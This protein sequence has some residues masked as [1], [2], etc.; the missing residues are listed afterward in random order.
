MGLCLC[1]GARGR[2]PQK[3]RD[4]GREGRSVPPSQR[5]QPEGRQRGVVAPKRRGVMG[6]GDGVS[7][8]AGGRTGLL[9]GMVA[10]KRRGIT[11][12]RDGMACPATG[13]TFWG[14]AGGR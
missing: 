2:S 13:R 9:Q 3:A 8:Y 1:R 12:W 10:P 11:G 7:C 6:R 4:H 14:A 5:L